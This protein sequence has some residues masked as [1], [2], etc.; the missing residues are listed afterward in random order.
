MENTN[1]Q[2]NPENPKE[3]TSIPVVEEQLKIE[4]KVIETGNLRLIK[5]VHEEEHEVNVALVQENVTVERVP[6]DRFVESPPPVRQ[7]GDTTIYPVLREVLVK[8]L[9]LVEEVRVTRNRTE[10][11]SPQKITLRKEEVQVNRQSEIRVEPIPGEK[12]GNPSP[13]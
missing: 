4:K 3:N 2:V 9:V 11:P 1:D 10:T 13:S 5:K 7:E 12:P 8:R 6:L